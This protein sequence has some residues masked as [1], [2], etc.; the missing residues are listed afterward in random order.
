MR[1]KAQ[2]KDVENL[3]K[4]LLTDYL[5]FNY[6]EIT[7][8]RHKLIEYQMNYYLD[9]V[10]IPITDFLDRYITILDYEIL[11]PKDGGPHTFGGFE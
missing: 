1:Q 9:D 7:E 4:L 6:Q 8:L 10:T 2:K 5:S 11:H 3:R